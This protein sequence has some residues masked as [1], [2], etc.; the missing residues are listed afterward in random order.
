MN[1]DKHKLERFLRS[2]RV[3]MA[4]TFGPI[5][6]L[7]SPVLIFKQTDTGRQLV[8]SGTLTSIDPDRIVLKK[9]VLTGIPI[10]VK[11]KHAVVKH[12]F[13]N[14]MVQQRLIIVLS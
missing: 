9:V 13:Y 11:K 4:S 6:Y 14:P 3:T 2:D 5:S 1:C 7:P 12:L 10:R 8:A